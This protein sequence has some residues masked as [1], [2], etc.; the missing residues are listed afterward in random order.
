M[1]SALPGWIIMALCALPAFSQDQTDL[2]AEFS[3][4]ATRFAQG[5]GELKVVPC[6]TTIFT[7]HPLHLTA[8][9]LA[10][11]NGIAFGPAFV[12]ENHT[13]PD[14]KTGNRW[15]FSWDVDAGVSSNL[16]WRAGAYMTAIF[17]PGEHIGVVQGPPPPK[18]AKLNLVRQYPVFNAYVQSES[19]NKLLY[20]GEGQG[21]SQAGLSYFG[22]RETIA[23]ANVLWTV[24]QPLAVAVFGEA[25]A[26]IVSLRPDQAPSGDPAISQLYNESTAP[27][28]ASQP[29]FGQ[30]SQGI[31][32]APSFWHNHAKLN[33]S[34]RLQ[35][36]VAPG[37]HYSFRRTQLDLSHEFPLYGSSVPLGPKVFNGPDSCAKDTSN[38]ACP[39]VVSLHDPECRLTGTKSFNREGSIGLR[40]L[41]TDSFTSA[42]NV[43]PFYFQPTLGGSDINGQPFLPSYGDYRFRGPNLM[44]LRASFEHS[45][46]GPF[47]FTFLVDEGR[48][49]LHPGD[50]GFNHLAHSFAA[51]VSL[52]AGG[53]PVVNFLFAW[54]GKEGTHSIALLS[55]E[56]LGG[57]ARPPL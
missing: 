3:G 17:V 4:E 14:P 6:A 2:G 20:Y 19:L 48:V 38:E 10:P 51:G 23:G 8:G 55:S 34:F 52:R 56:V 30:F 1:K 12:F 42:G 13:A 32:M 15:R 22:M 29:G 26:R 54:G 11:Q 49:A 39:C 27:G 36:Y 37:S 21:S 24:Y 16:S 57:S 43:V 47:G 31:Q 50:L 9:S 46:W 33:Y 7:D 18:G 53:F 45:I 25:N 40:F 41:L 44:L 28:L 5:C 35:E